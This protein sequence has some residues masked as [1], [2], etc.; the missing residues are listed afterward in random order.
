MHIRTAATRVAAGLICLGLAWWAQSP[1]QAA[2][3]DGKRWYKGNLHTHTSH[4]DGDSTAMEVAAWYKGNRY[5]F[6]VLTD[7]NYLTE[8]EGLNQAHAS[9]EK[10][11]L[12]P[13]EEITDSYG[14]KPVHVNGVALSKLV[15]PTGGA[16]MEATIQGNVSAIAAAGG[17]PSINHPNFGWAFGSKEL[18]QIQGASL[19]EVYNGHPGVNN[20]GGGGYESLDEMWDVLLT[21]GKRW[22]GI[23]VD[24]AHHF[25]VLGKQYS[26]PGRGW[27]MVRAGS[28]EAGA[29]AAA[30][31]T[32]DFY[33]STG[34]ELVSVETMEKGMRLEIKPANPLK[35]RTHFIGKGG[36]VLKTV[37]DLKVEYAFTDGDSYVRARVEASNGDA[38]WTQP[39]WK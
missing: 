30:I 33:S 27:V 15:L 6:L 34:V 4:S 29:I 38:A 10:F 19:F 14:G 36:K 37:T 18:L 11:L 16:T 9:Q 25:K 13:G 8:V 3:E 28:L 1:G 17:Q 23:A 26:N 21:A 12:I 24:D 2:P 31:R 32:G 20:A 35:Y 5:H 39:V 7:H 22:H